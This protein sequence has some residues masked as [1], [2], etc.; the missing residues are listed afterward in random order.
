V[1]E[2]KKLST[3]KDYAA[4]YDVHY[5]TVKRWKREGRLPVVETPGGGVRLLP[6]GT[7]CATGTTSTT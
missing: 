6:P 4:H 2:P 5:G 7:S 1:S 3:M